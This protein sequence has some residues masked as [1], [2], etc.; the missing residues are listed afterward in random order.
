MK[1]VG[2]TLYLDGLILQLYQSKK[3]IIFLGIIIGFPIIL[4][5]HSSQ[6]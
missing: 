2:H 1:Q 6:T 4:A 5:L 3:K